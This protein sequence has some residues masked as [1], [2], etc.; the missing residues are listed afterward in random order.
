MVNKPNGF[1]IT[2]DIRTKATLKLDS[3]DVGPLPF[4][5]G[6]HKEVAG[7]EDDDD[8]FWRL[9]WTDELFDER[10]DTKLV[11]DNGMSEAADDARDVVGEGR[12]VDSFRLFLLI[13]GPLARPLEGS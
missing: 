2:S 4:R 8:A 9:R 13:T 3:W 1:S 12:E 5:V 7:A 6:G 11:E 10:C